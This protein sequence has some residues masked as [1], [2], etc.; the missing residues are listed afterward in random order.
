MVAS[1]EV[2]YFNIEILGII[3]KKILRLSAQEKRPK[4]VTKETLL[5]RFF[6]HSHKLNIVEFQEIKRK[7]CNATQRKVVYVQ[8]DRP[9]TYFFHVARKKKNK[10]HRPSE[11]SHS[12]NQ[13]GSSIYLLWR[14]RDVNTSEE[15]RKSTKESCN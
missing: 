7:N 4:E 14:I 8:V 6:V 11:R 13:R 2:N 10:L 1:Q 15:R 12:N 9:E 3:E 5:R